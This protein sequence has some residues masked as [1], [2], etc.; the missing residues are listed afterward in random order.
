ME[1]SERRKPAQA[2][3]CSGKYFFRETNSSVAQPGESPDTKREADKLEKETTPPTPAI[4]EVVRRLG[5][6]E[7][8]RPAVSLLWSGAAA[9]L[10][11]SFSLLAQAILAA[12]L[13]DAPWRPLVVALGYPVGFLMVVL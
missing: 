9:G 1:A 2:E 5:E 8:R 4:Y 6:A 10:S 3:K 11:I 13:P 7:M 12:H